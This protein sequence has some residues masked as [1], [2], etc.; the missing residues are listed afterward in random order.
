MEEKPG[1]DDPPIEQPPA[2]IVELEATTRS[3]L[4]HCTVLDAPNMG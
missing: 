1:V 4:P 2:P 3:P